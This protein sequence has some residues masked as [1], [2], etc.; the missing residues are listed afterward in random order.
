MYQIEAKGSSIRCVVT[1]TEEK[2]VPKT[3][4]FNMRDFE[5]IFKIL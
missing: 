1:V 4:V 3:Q 5:E 2:N